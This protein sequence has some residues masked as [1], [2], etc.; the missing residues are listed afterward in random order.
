MGFLLQGPLEPGRA[1]VC[2]D[3]K[4]GGPWLSPEQD[5][6]IKMAVAVLGPS[7]PLPSLPAGSQDQGKLLYDLAAQ[8]PEWPQECLK[9][10]GAGGGGRW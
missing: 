9:P 3:P 4:P 7:H 1:V 10:S 5:A 6:Q 8:V 2:V